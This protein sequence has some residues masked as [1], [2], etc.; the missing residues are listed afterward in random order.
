MD[1]WSESSIE[2]LEEDPDPSDS[3]NRAFILESDDEDSFIRDLNDATPCFRA[4]PVHM[5]TS[6]TAVSSI[7]TGS[8]SQCAV[9]LEDFVVGDSQAVLPCSH[10]FHPDCVHRWLSRKSECPTCRHNVSTSIGGIVSRSRG[11]S[12]R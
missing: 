2:W 5:L 3:L 1:A 4:L 8:H 11:D 12:L 7:K 10:V 9:C 6:H